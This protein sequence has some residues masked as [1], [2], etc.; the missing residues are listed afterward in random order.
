MQSL[1]TRAGEG[2]LKSAQMTFGSVSYQLNILGHSAGGG[3]LA[4]NGDGTA[5]VRAWLSKEP[6]MLELESG[7]CVNVDITQAS[8][9]EGSFLVEGPVSKLGLS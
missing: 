7:E 9:G 2:A 8:F 3:A 4:C 6:V 5:I 1:M